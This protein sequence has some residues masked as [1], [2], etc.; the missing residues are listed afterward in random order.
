MF[1]WH[2]ITIENVTGTSLNNRVV[3][4]DC[5]KAM[6]CWDIT[7]KD[8]DVKPGKTDDDDIHFVCNNVVLGGDDGLNA[9]HPSNSE[10]ESAYFEQ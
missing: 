10:H 4:M 1:Q 2:N 3:Y 6:P 7:Y 5:S 9:C 8:F